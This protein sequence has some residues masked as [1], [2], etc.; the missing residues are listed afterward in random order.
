MLKY[1]KASTNDVDKIFIWANDPVVRKFS[2]NSEPIKYSKHVEW[3]N[4]KLNDNDSIF[5]IFENS[6][7]ESVGLVRIEKSENE[8]II[9]VLVD[10]K[11]RGKSYASK[12][13]KLASDAYQLKNKK[14]IQKQI[15]R[16]IGTEIYI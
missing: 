6:T 3:F 9:G 2:Y 1:R 8:I 11:Q 4:N 12:M 16:H 10:E 5:Y 13:L 15:K 14:D 7:N